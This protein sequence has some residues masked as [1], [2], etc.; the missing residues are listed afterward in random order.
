M[1]GP[2]SPAR[3]NRRRPRVTLDQGRFKGG[4]T[5][6]LAK[7][8][9]DQPQDQKIRS[10]PGT[11]F[12]WKLDR[13]DQR[14]RNSEK[15]R[16]KSR[17]FLKTLLAWRLFFGP[18]LAVIRLFLRPRIQW[19]CDDGPPSDANPASEEPDVV[20]R[21]AVDGLHLALATTIP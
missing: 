10:R 4:N 13:Q 21:G 17:T 18:G 12:R 14:K 2:W 11:C 8:P 3:R 1:I 20:R 5:L 7:G 9:I 15:R 19:G 6:A 16:W